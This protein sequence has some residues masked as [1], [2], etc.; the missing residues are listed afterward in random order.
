VGSDSAA[1]F[2]LCWLYQQ[3]FSMVQ[4]IALIS[5]GRWHRK[6]ISSCLWALA[7]FPGCCGCNTGSRARELDD[8]PG[9]VQRFV[10]GMAVSPFKHVPESDTIAIRLACQ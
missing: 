2:Y 7:A 10:C 4:V 1:M 8:L 6:I 9:V 3:R 5:S